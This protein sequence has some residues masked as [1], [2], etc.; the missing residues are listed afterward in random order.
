MNKP[1]LPWSYSSF[2]AYNTCPRRFYETKIAKNY[3]EETSEQMLWGTRVHEALE[4]RVRDKTPLP[5]EMVQYEKY[6]ATV[7]RSEGD[8]YCEIK[9]G[10]DAT[11]QPAQ[12]DSPTVW[13]RG[14]ED[15]LIV[16]GTKAVSLD[17]KTG[18]VK[19]ASKQLQLSALRVF[20]NFPEVEVVST[21][22]LWLKGAPPT[23]ATY[24][25]G[26]AG[27]LWD[28]FIEGVD[29][30]LWSESHDTWPAKR[31]GLCKNWCPVTSCVHN[32]KYRR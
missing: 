24:H 28:G 21:A 8:I 23:K 30:M 16:A 11:L 1:I 13:C 2:D 20:T 10:V 29:R 22:F 7:E 27:E 14:V 18:K 6:A 5:N 9:L 25:V 31:S 12:F 4:L 19:S 3:V 32:G 26:E 17:Y 15:V